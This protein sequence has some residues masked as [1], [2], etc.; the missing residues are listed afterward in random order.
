MASQ[1]ASAL[2][3]ALAEIAELVSADPAPRGGLSPQPALSKALARASVVLVVSHLE[4]FVR[5]SNEAA[6]IAVNDRGTFGERLPEL[7][8]LRHARL[9]IDE[10]SQTQW[11]KRSTG[12]VDFVTGNAWLWSAGTAGGLDPARLV[13]WMKT[14]HPRSLV[15]YYRTWGVHDVF[16]AITRTPHTRADLYLRLAEVVEKRNAIAHGDASMDATRSDIRA[17]VTAVAVF[18]GRADRVLAARLARLT[19]GTRP[20]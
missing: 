14:P 20:W 18:G 11:H 8:K 2:D 17:Y 6:A 7:L 5:A 9:P 15:K 13:D 3:A 12:L 4:R 1:A 16:D 19:G 10:A